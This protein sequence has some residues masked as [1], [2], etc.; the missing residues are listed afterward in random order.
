MTRRPKDDRVFLGHILE[1]IEVAQCAAL[2]RGT[3][4]ALI[5]RAVIKCLETIGEA[6]SCISDDL[7]RKHPDIP[8][9]DMKDMRNVLIHEYFGVSMALVWKVVETHLPLLKQQI[10]NILNELE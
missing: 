9:R 7:K 2:R 1:E 8:W 10:T 3:D 6:A 5:Q 4:D